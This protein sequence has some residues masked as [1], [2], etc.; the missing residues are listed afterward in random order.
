MINNAELINGGNQGEKS[1][2]QKGLQRKKP[3]NQRVGSAKKR[4]RRQSEIGIGPATT[5]KH[6]SIKREELSLQ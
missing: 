6:V 3:S 1:R 4:K 2:Y 5:K